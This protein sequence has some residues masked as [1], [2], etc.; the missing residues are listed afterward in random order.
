M[1]RILLTCPPMIKQ[2]A[3]FHERFAELGWD[4]VVPDFVQTVPVPELCTLA[5]EFDG[6]I[7]GDDS[8]CR[9]VVA[10]GAGG[11]L[12]AAVKW[13][14][15]TDNVDFDAFSEFSIPVINTPGAFGAEV[16]DIALGYL[17]GLARQTF[18]IDRDVRSGSWSKPV[19]A[20]LAEKTVALVGYGD[21]GQQFASR[22]RACGMRVQVYD[23][24]ASASD[25]EAAGFEHATWP[26]RLPEAD[27]IVFACAL[28]PENRHMLNGGVLQ[29]C[30][31]G[32]R[33]INVS[34]GGLIDE[35]ALH[36]AQLDGLVESCA[37]DVLEEEPVRADHPLL[38]DQRNIFGSHNASNTFEAVLR[39]SERAINLLEE[40]LG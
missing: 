9:E 22:A 30:M 25:V 5:P 32:V 33:V 35:D 14:V 37:L 27:F 19:G 15:G 11:K 39:T 28:T 2:V 34:R 8:A 40:F 16:A 29:T 17:I 20:S 1:T 36:Q 21:I 6:W 10:S 3:A 12:R 31:S 18:A 23:P 26:D 4:V 7:I 13:G 24:F 38:A